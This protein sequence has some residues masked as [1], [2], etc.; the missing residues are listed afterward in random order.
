MIIL[1]ACPTEAQREHAARADS[2]KAYCEGDITRPEGNDP[3]LNTL[4]WYVENSDAGYEGCNDELGD[5]R[6]RGPQPVG[7]RNPNAW[8][9]YDMHGNV[10]E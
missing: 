10:W 3:V 1:V 7:G 2:G 9:L 6:Y 5:G 8:G 4:G